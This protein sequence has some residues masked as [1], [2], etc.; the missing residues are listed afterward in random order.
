MQIFLEAV[1]P[2]RARMF[3]YD[4][5]LIFLEEKLAVEV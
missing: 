1:F 5:A 2:P 4:Y 3:E